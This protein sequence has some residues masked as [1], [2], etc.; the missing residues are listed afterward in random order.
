M[1]DENMTI[2]KDIARARK[3]PPTE[4]KMHE[5]LL[6]LRK[7]AYAWLTFGKLIQVIDRLGWQIEPYVGWVPLHYKQR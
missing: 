7:G 1:Y 3:K 2:D 6:K 4:E 5:S